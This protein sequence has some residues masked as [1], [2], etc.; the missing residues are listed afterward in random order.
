MS[1]RSCMGSNRLQSRKL[2]TVVSITSDL[3]KS[4]EMNNEISKIT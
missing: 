1:V 2:V 3:H 4:A